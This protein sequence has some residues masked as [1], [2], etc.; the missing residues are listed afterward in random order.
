LADLGQQGIWLVVASEVPVGIASSPPTG[1]QQ[2]EEVEHLQSRT[3]TI[4]SRTLGSAW[5]NA[6][7]VTFIQGARQLFRPMIRPRGCE[8]TARHR[9]KRS[10]AACWVCTSAADPPNLISAVSNAVR[11]M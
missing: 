8:G 7:F 4:G 11:G 5:R 2:V 1:V 3:P 9:L 10:N 6:R